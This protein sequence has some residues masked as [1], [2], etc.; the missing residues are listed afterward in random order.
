MG[1]KKSP[2]IGYTI[3]EVNK[4]ENGYFNLQFGGDFILDGEHFLFTKAEI[5]RLYKKYLKDLTEIIEDGSEK[6]RKYA[7]D[8]IATMTVKQMRLH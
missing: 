3:E 7:L 8:L 1:K 6:D 5:S 4:M 2:Y